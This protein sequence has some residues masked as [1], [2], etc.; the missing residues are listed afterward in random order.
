MLQRFLKAELFDSFKIKKKSINVAQY[1]R[2]MEVENLDNQL[3]LD[4]H[5]CKIL[6]C[7]EYWIW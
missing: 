6:Q 1:F 5:F 7:G 2:G 3:L 4:W